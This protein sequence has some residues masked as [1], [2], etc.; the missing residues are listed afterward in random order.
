MGD[1]PLLRWSSFLV[2][3]LVFLLF[4]C[5]CKVLLSVVLFPFVKAS[6]LQSWCTV[7]CLLS[8]FLPEDINMLEQS[9][10]LPICW[11]PL[12]L[13]HYVLQTSNVN[14]MA[15]PANTGGRCAP[16]KIPTK[17]REFWFALQVVKGYTLPLFFCWVWSSTF[18]TPPSMIYSL[19]LTPF[20]LQGA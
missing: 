9:P 19:V 18:T 3:F 7:Y 17:E 16:C 12:C 6:A 1:W 2:Y 8:F 10:V 11:T 13:P 14:I 15:W 5:P 20:L 4:F